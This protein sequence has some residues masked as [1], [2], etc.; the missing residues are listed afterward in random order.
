MGI[1]TVTRSARPAFA[2]AAVNPYAVYL[3]IIYR[4]P[5]IAQNVHFLAVTKVMVSAI[6][7]ELVLYSLTV[8]NPS[9]I[10]DCAY[11]SFTSA[12]RHEFA[13]I[14]GGTVL[15]IARSDDLG[16]I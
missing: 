15:E 1:G 9:S 3:S 11:G 4:T 8:R 14:K 12:G 5:A 10:T 2:G 6:D 16:R 13:M 7:R